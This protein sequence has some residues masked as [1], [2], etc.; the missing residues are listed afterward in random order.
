MSWKKAVIHPEYEIHTDFTQCL[1]GKMC[2]WYSKSKQEQQSKV[3]KILNW[4]STVSIVTEL[5][6]V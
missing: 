4:D 2:C 5:W 1:V 3:Y 6:A